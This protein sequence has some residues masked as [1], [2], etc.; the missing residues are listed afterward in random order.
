MKQ[1]QYDII[2]IGAGTAGLSAAIYA[3]RGGKHTLVLEGQNYGGQIIYAKEVENYPGIKQISGIAFATE[4]YEQAVGLGVEI[5][6]DKVTEVKT[7]GNQKLVITAAG[8]YVCNAVI[9]AMGA[10]NRKL[11][12]TGEEALT[13]S[14]VSYCAA[15]DGAFYRGKSVAVVGGGNTALEDAAVLSEYCGSVFLIHRRD[16]FR[17]EEHALQELKKKENV[18]ILTDTI[19]TA[20]EGETVLQGISI[21]HTKTGE[22][23]KLAVQGLFVAVGQVPQNEIVS[24]FI[25]M[26]HNGYIQA[27]ESCKTNIPGIYAAGDCRTKT[28]RQ[29]ATAASDGVIAALAACQI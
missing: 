8:S 27:D 7:D 21:R 28:V 10:K 20:L 11:G 17:G 18:T 12:L 5:I 13:G 26:D 22:E 16:S 19:V 24:D 4:L 2:I 9:L 25:E 3:A 6:Y 14:G 23:R 1:A 15:C 29:L